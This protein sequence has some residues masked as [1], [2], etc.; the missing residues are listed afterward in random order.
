MGRVRRL[1]LSLRKI[2]LATLLISLGLNAF[3][4]GQANGNHGPSAMFG[5]VV[6]VWSEFGHGTGFIVDP[7]GL[8]LTSQQVIGPS[9][10]IAVQFDPQHK[11]AATLLASDNEKDIAVLWVNL[12]PCPDCV[13]APIAMTRDGKPPEVAVGE[14]I[15]AVSSPMGPLKETASGIVDAVEREEYYFRHRDQAVDFRRP[16]VRYAGDGD[17]SNLGRGT[18]DTWEGSFE[19]RS[20]RGGGSPS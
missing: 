6:T 17:R 8:I 16:G 4:Y 5:S 10:I 19:D 18:N 7:K 12:S 3:A 14:K 1:H 13:A 9:E 2:P 11:V 20:H 15:T